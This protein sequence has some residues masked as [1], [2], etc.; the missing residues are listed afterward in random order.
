MRRIAAVIATLTLFTAA[1]GCMVRERRPDG[2]YRAAEEFADALSDEAVDCAKEHTPAGNG[3]V[4]VAA[5]FTGEGQAPIVH[6]AG[7]MQ[8]GDAFLLCVRQRASEKLKSPAKTPAKFVRV[9][10]PV[11]VDTKGVTYAF[12][13]ELKP[14]VP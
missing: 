4:V 13:A 5:E 10:V 7:S 14:P 2:P 11:P 9:K 3:D 8:G 6:D 12:M 1:S